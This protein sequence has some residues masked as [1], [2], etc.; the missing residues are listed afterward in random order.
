[1]NFSDYVQT[2]LDF[3]KKGVAFQDFSTLLASPVAF[4]GAI[5]SIHSHYMH[6]QITDIAAIE[7]KGFALGGGLSLSMQL[8]LTL[9]RKTG[10][11]PGD[12]SRQTFVKEYGHGEYEIRKRLFPTESRVLI[13]YDILA[14]VGATQAAIRLVES[15]GARVIGCAYVVELMYLK[16][17]EALEP[18]DLFSLVKIAEKPDRRIH[19]E[20]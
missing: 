16:G 19:H 8:P 18:Y 15:Q 11:I 4:K 7:A 17:R 13:L 10:L 2:W 6:H 9:I 5:D 12:V 3:P 1:M 14:G 20:Q